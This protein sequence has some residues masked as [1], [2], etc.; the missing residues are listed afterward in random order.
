MGLAAEQLQQAVVELDLEEAAA[1]EAQ[2]LEKEVAP[3]LK[4]QL[5]VVVV[6]LDLKQLEAVLVESEKAHLMM[7]TKPEMKWL[8]QMTEWRVSEQEKVAG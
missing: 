7:P 5:S 6:E 3:A 2:K 8:A 1:A 4:R